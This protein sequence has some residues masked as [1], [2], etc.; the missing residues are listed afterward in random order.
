MKLDKG[1]KLLKPKAIYKIRQHNISNLHIIF[2]SGY[3][4]N[5]SAYYLS[6][7]YFSELMF[8]LNLRKD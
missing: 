7:Y 3:T 4:L 2:L 6:I 1:I 5:I 8:T